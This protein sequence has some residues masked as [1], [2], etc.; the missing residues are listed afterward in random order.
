MSRGLPGRDEAVRYL[1]AQGWLPGE[2]WR[3]GV[4]WSYGEFDVLVPDDGVAD[5]APRMRALTRCVGE[6]E[7]RSPAVVARDLVSGGVDVIGYRV[8]EVGD[9]ISLEATADAL[10]ALQSLLLTCAGQ[11]ADEDSG[12]RFLRPG[13]VGELLGDVGLQTASDPSG[14][15]LFLPGPENPLT[16][17]TAIRLLDVASLAR[18]TANGINDAESF[19]DPQ[20]T[21]GLSALG[22]A[23]RAPTRFALSFTWSR[24]VPRPDVTVDFPRELV[25]RLGEEFAIASAP[26]PS[27]TRTE[28]AAPAVVEGVVVGIDI[29]GGHKVIVRGILST[30][31][32]STGR[33]RRITVLVRTARE[34]A[35]ASAL[36]GTRT[37]VRARGSFDGKQSLEAAE[38]GFTVIDGN[39]S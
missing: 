38:N 29:D 36:V 26:L 39:P 20:I 25:G 24:Q 9:D 37:Q 23:E 17:L 15:D 2:V 30:G 12:A 16:R 34:F 22:L 6:L 33:T 32:T 3:H 31:D 27:T 18:Q 8:G 14:F 21:D 4:I 10:V 5:F 35:Q 7:R 13:M 1:S 28:L 11:V 19:V